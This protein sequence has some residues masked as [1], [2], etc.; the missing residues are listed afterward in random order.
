MQLTT[1]A[2]LHWSLFIIY[3]HQDKSYCVA[4]IQHL[5]SSEGHQEIVELLLA[6]KADVTSRQYLNFSSIALR[7]HLRLV[8][9]SSLYILYL[10]VPVFSDDKLSITQTHHRRDRFKGSPL[11]DAVRHGYI[12]VQVG[13]LFFFVGRHIQLMLEPT[14][15]SAPFA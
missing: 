1:M 9:T 8:H 15:S 3:F 4:A 11:D 5:S 7:Y 12:L 2:G 13:V 14:F 6:H 10:S